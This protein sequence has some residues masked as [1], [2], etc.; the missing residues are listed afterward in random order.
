VRTI[1]GNTVGLPTDCPQ[2]DE[3]LGWMADTQLIAPTI[4]HLFD[5]GP[6]FDQ[7]LLAVRDGQS[8]TGAFPDV[9]PKLVVDVDGAPGWA[10]A[11]VLV[12]WAVH[13]HDGDR[14]R[15]ARHYPAMVRFLDWI[16]AANRDLIRR[17]ALQHNY[18]DWLAL[19]A[20]VDKA[21]LATAYWAFDVTVMAAM[22]AAL[23][24][25][26]DVERWKELARRLRA[27]FAD[28]FIGDAT[29]LR[30]SGQTA[31]AMALAL[32]LVPSELQPLC[33]SRLVAAIDAA[34]GALATGIHGTRFLLPALCDTGH[35][36]VAYALLT[37]RDYPSWQYSIEQ[38]A[39]TIW[40]R[41]DGS[42]I[43]HG[44]QTPSLNSMNHPALGSVAEWMHAYVAGLRP[45]DD[46]LEI[47]PY[48]GGG[49]SSAL[50]KTNVRGSLAASTWRIDGSEIELRCTVPP[51]VEA[52]ICVPSTRAASHRGWEQHAA[53]PGEWTFRAPWDVSWRPGDVGHGLLFGTDR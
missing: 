28:E 30:I 26:D 48:P 38:G 34:G 13:R 46:R 44:L 42:T 8:A 36:D 7:W 25:A 6:F 22:A 9:A 17:R 18:G 43:E 40:E 14:G 35:V 53:G 50:S 15:L 52:I 4:A 1:R 33:A 10:D 12:P 47:R 16:E 23:G 37:R 27:A 2:R 29:N 51:G 21:L 11:G 39:T 31:L 19:E 5:S 20:P 24:H 45:A 3:R 32:D 41:W 49:L